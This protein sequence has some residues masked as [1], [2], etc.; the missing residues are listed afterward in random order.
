M[1]VDLS[2]RL[3]ARHGDRVALTDGP[4][5][6]SWTYREL[7]LRA[8]AAA[9]RL[10]E[11]GLRSGDRISVLAGPEIE[12]VALFFGALKVGATLVP[13]NLRLTGPEL[14]EEVTRVHPTLL[15]RGRL[16]PAD[17]AAGTL[18]GW[19]S[20]SLEELTRA[21]APTAHVP[22]ELP[23]WETPALILFTGGSTGRPK[24][25][26][27]SLRAV[28]S[29]ALTTAEGWRLQPDDSTI[30][31]FPMFHTGGWNVLLLPLLVMGGRNVFLDRFDPVEILRRIDAEKITLLGG[32]PSMFIELVGRPEFGRASL[33]SLR[34]AKSGGGNSPE[35]VVDAFRRRG[36]PFYQGYGLTEAGPNLLYSTP[37]DLARPTTI[38]RPNLMCDLKLVDE[39]GRE[40]ALGELLVGGPVLFSGYLDNPDATAAAMSGGYVRTGDVLRRDADGFYY[41]VG[42]TKLM[43]KS[44]G[45]NVYIA[46]VEQALE[47]HPAVAEAAVIGVPD[48]KW[49]EV[50]RA[51]L[52]ERSPVAEE[53]L[54]HYLRERLAAYK[55][56]KTFVR[57]E[58]LPHT[59]AGKKD[60]PRLTRERGG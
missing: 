12:L 21:G 8:V 55:V 9:S 6:V 36:I 27:L 45:E 28:L 14:G 7:E 57:V 13:H 53:E 33:A 22:G 44:G 32:V 41:F 40:S 4:R 19:P 59:R 49:G 30:L 38:G 18:G 39:Q 31:V 2:A 26:V 54:R 1:R 17:F 35:A 58:E 48:P 25:A 15:V 5:Q 60:Y 43:F 24:G 47:S 16:L 11:R 3:A 42:R 20:A 29:N 51:F 50:G 52:V 37:D 23:D 46:E 10:R 34:F 56:P